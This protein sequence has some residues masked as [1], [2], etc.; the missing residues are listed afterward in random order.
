MRARDL[1]I[2]RGALN[3]GLD[4]GRGRGAAARFKQQAKL[5]ALERGRLDR[6][7]HFLIFRLE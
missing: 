1:E 4:L 3:R 6:P 2:S 7:I 5:Q